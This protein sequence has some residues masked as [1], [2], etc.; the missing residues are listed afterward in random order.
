[1][2]NYGAVGN[3]NTDNTAA[4]S[5]CL[6]ALIAA[7]GGRMYLPAGVYHGKITIP[8]IAAPNWIALEI[9]G[10]SQPAPIF[11]TVGTNKLLNN[12]SIVKSLATVGP[13]VI[14]A[15]DAAG[16]FSRVSVVV[17]DL[18]VRTYDNPQID[19]IDLE[20]AQQCRV[21]NVVI[22]S[23]VYS[24]QASRPTHGTKGLVTPAINN[25]ALTILRNVVVSGYST[26]IEVN[27]H[28]DGDHLNLACN[29]NGLTFVRAY[30]ASRFGRV[31][32]YRCTR[33]INVIGEHGFSIEQLNVEHPGADQTDSNN[34]WQASEYDINDAQNLGVGDVNY[35][36]VLGNVGVSKVFTKSGG[37]FR[38]FCRFRHPF[39]EH[40]SSAAFREAVLQFFQRQ[41]VFPEAIED[42]LQSINQ[43]LRILAVRFVNHLLIT[44][45]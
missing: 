25:G 28:T 38:G 37:I 10:E 14:S 22:E 43:D 31:G 6:T 35:W 3:D 32:A 12:N 39:F 18:Q 15:G 24:V 20:W 21:E 29:L 41:E 16:D 8:A 27:E 5:S 42:C 23:G 26:G 44:V 2:L 45:T 34:S 19:G 4:F 1:M 11:G 33:A 30:H 36:V 7:G 9:V 13:A 17:K 40:P